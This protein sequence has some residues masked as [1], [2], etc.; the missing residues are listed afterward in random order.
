[1]CGEVPI[2]HLPVC[3]SLRHLDGLPAVLVDQQRP[4]ATAT[5][6]AQ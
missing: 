5:G 1:L 3:V 4:N 6:H 2:G